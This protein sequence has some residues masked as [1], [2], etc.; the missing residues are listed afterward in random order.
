MRA[1]RAP[2]LAGILG[3]PSGA[4]MRRAA[5]RGGPKI[6]PESSRLSEDALEERKWIARLATLEPTQ[7]FLVALGRGQRRLALLVLRRRDVGDPALVGVQN[8]MDTGV[9]AVKVLA[10][11]QPAGVIEVGG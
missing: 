1:E 9:E 7:D 2:L 3:Q 5:P 8:R 6:T 4:K 11:D 10:L